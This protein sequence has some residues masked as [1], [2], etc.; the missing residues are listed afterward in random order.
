MEGPDWT[1]LLETELNETRDLLTRRIISFRQVG[2]LYRRDAEIHRLAL[3]E[4]KDVLESLSSVGFEARTLEGYGAERMPLGLTGF[5][6]R[7]PLH[8][9]EVAGL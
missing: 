1:V 5:L 2:S 6:G 3:V 4:P 8:G 9:D 7:K